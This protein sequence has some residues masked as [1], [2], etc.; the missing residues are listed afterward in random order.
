MRSWAVPSRSVM[1]RLSRLVA[2]ALTILATAPAAL[3]QPYWNVEGWGDDF[4]GQATAP[5]GLSGVTDVAAGE[6]HSLALLGDSTVVAWGSDEEGQATVPAGLSG[7]AAIAAGGN[8]SLALL[9]DSTVVAWGRQATA[10]AGLTGV[11]AISTGGSYSLA[12]KDD[13]TVV[14]WGGSPRAPAGLSGVV[15]ISVGGYHVLA[16]KSDGTVVSWRTR[17]KSGF[18]DGTQVPAG[19]T[20]VVAVAAGGD[21]VDERSLALKDDGTVVEWGSLSGP[22]VPAGLSGVVA[23]AAGGDHGLAV[24][25]DGTVVAWGTDFSGETVVPDGLTNVVAVAGGVEHSLALRGGPAPV[26]SATLDGPEGWRMLASPEPTTVGALLGDLW[27][28]GYTGSDNETGGCTVFTFDESAAS[29]DAAW[30]CVSDAADALARG[31]GLMVYVFA[32]DDM[33]TDGVQGGFPKTLTASASTGPR[34]DFGFDSTAFTDDDRPLTQ[35]GW[36]LLGVPFGISFDWDGAS[37]SGVTPTVYVFDPA[38]AGGAYRSYTSEG[39]VGN[40]DLANG[41]LPPFQGFLVKAYAPSPSL[42]MPLGGGGGEAQDIYGKHGSGEPP[43]PPATPLQSASVVTA[44]GDTPDAVTALGTVAPNPT[45]G[46]ATV[47]WA[48]AEAG[49]ARVSVVDLLGREVAAIAEGVH[50]AG[51]HRSDLP[52]GLAPGVYLVR[53]TAGAVAEVARFTVVR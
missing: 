25:D 33:V 17:N 12:L 53:L 35:K 43:T 15:A 44:S 41:L 32:D 42:V 24:K 28:Q 22:S 47:A 30:T 4:F 52:A 5:A 31:Q 27:T 36:N 38:F 3:A 18:G 19:L 50:Q 8:Q 6:Y 49:Q 14:E 1:P 10:P 40:G 29:F 37:R 51:A 23:I 48:L 45:R 34:W 13:G 20:G 7:V 21:F 9:G 26:A 11:V 39:G 46:A 2:L 16:L